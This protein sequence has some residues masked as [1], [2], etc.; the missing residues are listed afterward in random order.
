MRQAGA[1][2]AHG[3]H[4]A[5]ESLLREVLREHPRWPPA[6]ATLGELLLSLGRAAEAV[7]LL[8]QAAMGPP[9]HAHAA[10]VLARFYNDTQRP[11]EA[12][13]VAAPL[14]T[15][16]QAD[17]ALAAQHVAALAA[18]GRQAE[19][20][21]GY[22][23]IVAALP[24]APAASHAL[25]IALAAA[26]RH[27][28][29]IDLARHLLA[30]GHGNAA[31]HH[32]MGRSL[33]ARGDDG[34]AER[35][36]QHCLRLER[37]HSGALDELAQLTWLRTGDLS[38]ATEP[39]EQALAVRPGDVALTAAKAAIQQGAGD[40]RAAYGTL[41]PLA[42]RPQAPPALL[43]RAALAALEFD[44]PAALGLAAR[45]VHGL[46]AQAPA[47]SVLAAAQLGVGDARAALATCEPL[48][49]ATP[50][51]Q[52]LI[53]LQSTALRLLGDERYARLCDYQHLVVPMQLEAP[54]G[55]SDLATFLGD[56]KDSLRRLHDPHGHP[57]LFQSLRGGT[58]TA[59]DLVRSTDPVI[60]ALFRAFAA[61]IERY[62]AHV[63]RGDDPLR[64]RNTGRW[65][66]NG[67]W[68]VRLRSAGYH[69]VHTHPRG[70]ISSAC[71][72]E[73]PD[74]MAG[75]T[76]PDGTLAF[77]EPGFPTTPRL[78]PEYSVRPAVGQLVLFPSYF[79]HG[80]VPFTS[81]QPRTTVAFDVVPLP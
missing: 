64:R 30:A 55:W 58:E 13:R 5:A 47:R 4:A 77:G 68:S 25:A 60:Q 16:G 61:P 65:R 51:D 50:D 75:A 31:L 10:Q 3:D 37:C 11:A 38:Q 48:L 27:E 17:A 12:L 18:L 76:T 54:A 67:A 34:E 46:P 71:Y 8:E 41:A 22:R 9:V 1:R 42:A 28:E 14:C 69:T 36:F 26:G 39:F 81:E 45:A 21:E 32:L 63:G 6:L 20:V 35:E 23:R 59:V 72:I 33:R 52:Y 78:G 24:N 29:A 43:L 62:L 73:L 2:L 40:A 57:L 19:A 56:L 44:P 79:W 80:T 70:W 15:S 49:A 7:P 53:A 66:F 74:A